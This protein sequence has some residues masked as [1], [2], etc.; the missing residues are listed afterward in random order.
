[1][2]TSNLFRAT[3]VAECTGT[4]DDFFAAIAE[5][6]L[7]LSIRLQVEQQPIRARMCGFGDKVSPPI[8]RPVTLVQD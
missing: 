2:A 4:F 1:M 7:T 3:K 8:S 5:N 6:K